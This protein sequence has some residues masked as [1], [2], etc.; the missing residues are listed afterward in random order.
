MRQLSAALGSIESYEMCKHK[1]LYE[2]AKDLASNTY[3]FLD[4]KGPGLGNHATNQFISNLSLLAKK[5]F[6]ADFS[7][8]RVC[9]SSSLAVD[10]YFPD[11]GIIVEVALGLK[12][13]NTEYE[14]DIIKAIMAK[15]LGNRVE[16]LV[17][18]TKPGGEKKC[19]Q[20]GRCAVKEWLCNSNAIEVEVWDL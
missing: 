12:N 6:G 2:I 18:I 7:E 9:G 11:E 15:N 16:K 14:K 13:S 20:P 3:G 1:K 4:S 10:F 5:E 17:Y 19:N 8:K